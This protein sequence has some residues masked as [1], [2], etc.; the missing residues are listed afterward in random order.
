MNL[1]VFG[2]VVT[3]F[4]YFGTNLL[5][6]GLH[7]YGFTDSGAEYLVNF[8]VGQGALLG[9][10]LVCFQAWR[11]FSRDADAAFNGRL[12]TWLAAFD[13]AWLLMALLW[14]G[15]VY[16]QSSLVWFGGIYESLPWLTFFAKVG[17]YV[18]LGL[19]WVLAAVSWLP[20]ASPAEPKLTMPSAAPLPAK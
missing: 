7:S 1:A 2:N 19:I 3:S 14:F 11:S 16:A 17:A 5:G 6:I 9:N 12:R 18:C 8:V 13:I 15:G 4:S 10:G 20:F